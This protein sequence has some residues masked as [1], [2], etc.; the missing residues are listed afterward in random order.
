MEV[1]AAFSAY[2]SKTFLTERLLAILFAR[3]I[4]HPFFYLNLESSSCSLSS[5]FLEGLKPRDFLALTELKL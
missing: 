1:A 2:L 4:M 3:V 5:L